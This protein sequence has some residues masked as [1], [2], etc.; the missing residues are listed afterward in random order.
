M[1]IFIF[2]DWRVD[3][4]KRIYLDSPL[5]EPKDS[6]ILFEKDTDAIDAEWMQVEYMQKLHLPENEIVSDIT[7]EKI[8]ARMEQFDAIYQTGNKASG[9]DRKYSPEKNKEL[10]NI[11]NVVSSM[12]AKNQDDYKREFEYWCELYKYYEYPSD[13]YQCSRAARDVLEVA[14]G[15]LDDQELL[16]FASESIYYS[17]NFLGYANR[18]V[19]SKNHPIIKEVDDIAFNNGKVYYQLYLEAKKRQQLGKYDKEFLLSAYAC[20]KQAEE[21]MAEDN[22]N[23]ALVTYYIGNICELMAMEMPTDNEYYKKIVAE[24]MNYYTKALE[25]VEK[26]DNYYN[27][28]I[29]MRQNIS[30]GLK[31]VGAL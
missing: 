30:D 2:C 25:C 31:T 24:S 5:A 21:E 10:E 15:T 23:Y 12:S 28:E 13:I 7:L 20:M 26:I 1:I 27:E 8:E 16:K 9:N 29:N 4:H 6:D 17:E 11:R 3:K 18:N 14:H 19:S 22:V